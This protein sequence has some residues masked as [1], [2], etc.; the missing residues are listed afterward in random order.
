MRFTWQEAK[1][2]S[3]LKTHGLDFLDAPKVFEGLTF[4]FEDDRF[5][6]GEQ[7]FV[8]LG[9]LN[10]IP[11]SIVHTET[12]DH[13]HVISFRKATKNEQIIFFENI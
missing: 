8:T 11:V 3:N 4:T 9:L 10:G 13:I 1:R 6:Y 12:A 2:K 5:E 7:R